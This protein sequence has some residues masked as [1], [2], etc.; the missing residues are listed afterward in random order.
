[1]FRIL[2]ELV[3]SRHEHLDVEPISARF[4]VSDGGGERVGDLREDDELEWDSEE[5]TD[6]DAIFIAEL[7]KANT[8]VKRLDLARNGIGPT[9]A[10]AVAAAL[11]KF[12]KA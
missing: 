10:A 5:Y 9:G 7:L 11:K 3:K 4:V 2:A 8:T 12:T 1:M 6:T